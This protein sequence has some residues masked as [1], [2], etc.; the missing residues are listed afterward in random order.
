MMD[1]A[2]VSDTDTVAD[3]TEEDIREIEIKD[4]KLLRI[5]GFDGTTPGG[6]R[7]HPDGIHV[8]YSLGIKLIVVNWNNG[9]QRFLEGHTNNVTSIDVS[10]SGK[11]V[12]SGQLNYMVFKAF[13]CVW[14]FA[15]GA[16]L[17][18]HDTHKVRVASVIFSSCESFLF[19]LGG[20]DDGQVVVYDVKNKSAICGGSLSSVASG[21]AHTLKAAVTRGK[22][23]LSGGEGH[24]KTWTV[25]PAQRVLTE[26]N[27]SLGKIRRVITC[28]EI[29]SDDSYAYCGT[30]S[31]DILKLNLNYPS[32]PNQI[33]QS[34]PPVLMGCYGKLVKKKVSSKLKNVDAEDVSL[35]SA[36]VTAMYLLKDGRL[37][38]GS[39]LGLVDLVRE[40]DIN[41]STIVTKQQNKLTKPSVPMLLQEKCAFT[42]SSVTSLQYNAVTNKVFVGTANCEIF[43][44]DMNGGGF[45][46]TLVT[47][48]HTSTIYDIQFP[49]NFASVF[50][51][52]SKHDIRIWSVRTL[53][54]LLRITVSNMVCSCIVFTY[55]GKAIL[56][57]WNDGFIR[58]FT[59]QSGK[60]KY[61][62]PNAHN[63]GVTALAISREHGN[64]TKLLS[65][66]G[67]GQVR[68]WK[69]TKESQT[70]DLVLKEHTSSVSVI[71]IKSD[72]KEA[73]SA[74]IDGTCVIWDIIR[75]TRLTIIILPSMIM[76]AA[77]HPSEVQ[78]ITCSTNK[79][80]DYWETI[81]GSHIR[82]LEGSEVAAVNCVDFVDD[83][84]CFVTGGADQIVKVWLYR[85]GVPC[86]VGIG[87]AAS[88]TKLRVS[89]D[90]SVI[91]SV[92]ADGGIFLWTFPD[93]EEK[94][95]NN[96]DDTQS[97]KSVSVSN[98]SSGSVSKLSLKPYKIRV[99]RTAS[100]TSSPLPRNS[101]LEKIDNINLKQNVKSA[102]SEDQVGDGPNKGAGGG[103]SFLKPLKAQV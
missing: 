61:I 46:L 55:D 26:V 6:L 49:Y 8:I 62:I 30:T 88:I 53:N 101:N 78:L 41:V 2:S 66:G 23:F 76:S 7:L 92:S 81:D 74:S 98:S 95:E 91:V 79:L 50:A 19:S 3:T 27:V 11:Y 52:C 57:G 35:Y 71:K 73:M 87:H 10:R 83:G 28:C 45:I 29:T 32:D 1:T 63:K 67:E 25:D 70:L 93:L 36:G 99:H 56:S 22:C 15:S 17:I 24:L 59:P 20:Q 18:K 13:V 51:T 64:G 39:G 97:V 65:G 80:I 47:T 69:L 96:K 9:T 100:S 89:P 75:G 31:G 82:S 14:D 5:V 40:R 44:I 16:L 48:C 77:Y 43:L 33:K 84:K 103:R 85:E 34:S 58:C 42:N 90:Q 37:L 86:H 102:F 4:L 54:E 68:I 21:T 12:A 72:D 94:E 38:V 60:L